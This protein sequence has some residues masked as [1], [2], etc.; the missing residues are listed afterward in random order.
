MKIKKQIQTIKINIERTIQGLETKPQEF[1]YKRTGGFVKP[2]QIYSIYY[3]T[4]KTEKYLTGVL[5]TSN[6]KII[7][8]VGIKSILN[9]YAEVKPTSRQP[10]PKTT[11]ANPNESDYA[12]GVIDRFFTRVGND[13]N[14][15]IFEI[16]A[17]DFNNRNN[18]YIYFKSEWIIS[19]VKSAVNRLN[20]ATISDLQINYPNITQVLF[21]L[22]L[23]KPPKNSLDDLEN[24]LERLKTS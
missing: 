16:T 23:W 7:E 12:I 4:N 9:R 24:K 20:S 22:Q 17:D 21:P 2:N 13:T 18:L 15:P 19:G 3:T 1:R 11:P 14:K 8:K 6:S 10:Y 5:E